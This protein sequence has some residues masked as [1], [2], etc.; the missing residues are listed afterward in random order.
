[1]NKFYNHLTSK[2][3]SFLLYLTAFIC[4][5]FSAVWAGNIVLKN[6]S[7]NIL[8]EGELVKFDGRMFVIKSDHFGEMT[9][10]SRQY[11]C[12]SGTCPDITSSIKSPKAPK[13]KLSYLGIYGSYTI[14]R[15]LLPA[16]VDAYAQNTGAT[17]KRIYTSDP[18]KLIIN[19]KDGLGLQMSTVKI[20]TKG[21][22]KSFPA[23]AS[24]TAQIAMSSRPIAGNELKLLARSG[25][26]GMTQPGKENILALDGLQIVLSP[27]N[28]VNSL[29][30]EQVAKIFAGKIRNWSQLGPYKGKIN[31]HTTNADYG[32]H[33]IFDRLV[34][35]PNN[36]KM[37]SATKK[38][39]SYTA[40]S[41]AV[42]RDPLG[43]GYTSSSYRRNAKV[44][45]VSTSCSAAKYPN[46]FDIKAEEY[47]LSFRHY[48][49]VHGLKSKPYA[50]KLVKFAL[51]GKAQPVL[52]K[53]GFIDMS[54][55]SLSFNDQ[56]DRII[57]GVAAANR[58]FKV[59]LIDQFNR[60]FKNAERLSTTFRFQ[61]N[62]HQL[63]N[64][65]QIDAHNLAKLLTTRKY[66]NKEVYLVGFTDSRGSTDQNIV[67]ALTRADK[68]KS[69]I[70]RASKGKI[71]PYRLNVRGYGELLP[72]SCNNT[73][74][75]R[76]KNRRVEVWLR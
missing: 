6:S 70:I 19:V 76:Y 48:L 50:K 23:L 27:G 22:K 55:V 13:T 31:I 17:T 11:S 28:P 25:I 60:M 37:A 18:H 75:G 44:I 7:S 67:V 72:V 34:M 2:I 54:P 30:V 14:G 42:A 43:I 21:S 20:L 71:K 62:N 16:L 57:T 47:P 12:V 39:T 41:D 10:S 58:D 53:Q 38:Y 73:R 69:A 36:L 46:A 68:V 66:K 65:S 74:E 32:L 9:V 45:A 40:L 59:S 49:Y 64:K 15:E 1:M 3:I 24:G 52:R 56:A 33:D 51:S 5:Q 63:D 29:S 61:G 8:I 26:V 4:C 35:Q